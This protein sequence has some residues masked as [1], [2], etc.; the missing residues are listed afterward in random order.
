MRCQPGDSVKG[1]EIL[2]GVLEAT[3]RDPF[4]APAPSS[5]EV[6][7]GATRPLWVSQRLDLDPPGLSRLDLVERWFTELTAKKL[8]AHPAQARHRRLDRSATRVYTLEQTVNQLLSS[9]A[10]YCNRIN[11]SRD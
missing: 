11:G 2:T 6:T 7:K 4:R 8:A 3:M 10:N 5:N 1:I 9:N